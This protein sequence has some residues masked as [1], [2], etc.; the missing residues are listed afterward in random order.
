MN[1]MNDKISPFDERIIDTFRGDYRFLSNFYPA[2]LIL[3]GTSFATSEHAYQ[4][5]KTHDEAEKH[6]IRFTAKQTETSVIEVPS[7]AA[8]SKSAGA[9]VTKRP[10]WEEVRYEIMVEILRAKFSQNLDLKE[11]LLTTDNAILIEG[12]TWHD[13]TWGVCRCESC[14]NFGKNLLGKALMQVRREL[15]G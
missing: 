1:Y 8:E 12:N 6:S 7:T 13:R 9:I 3:W 4:W 5:S 11:K 14:G 15:K 10:D 2:P